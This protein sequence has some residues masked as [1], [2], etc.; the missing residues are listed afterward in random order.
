MRF[1]LL[2]GLSLTAAMGLSLTTVYAGTL[3]YRVHSGDSLYSIARQYHTSVSTLENWNHL[4]SDLIHPGQVL[5]VGQTSTD[6]TKALPSAEKSASTIHTTSYHATSQSSQSYTVQSG[7]SLWSISRK[8]GVTVRDIEL[9]NGLSSS[10][11]IHAGQHLH[12]RGSSHQVTMLSSR[13]STPDNSLT[14]AAVGYEIAQ[15]AKQFVGTPYAWG[16]TS[17]SGFDCSG[18]VQYVYA[19]FGTALPRTSYDQFGVGTSV[20]LSD[21]EPG[22]ILFFDTFGSGASHDG[23]Y[24]GNGEFINAASVDV[25]IDSISSAYWGGHFVGAKRIES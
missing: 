22:D 25:E 17:P 23:I 10:S 24:L 12:I 1:K 15:Y 6:G 5:V 11:V 8:F 20:S 2:V 4:H 14:A 16:G 18:F 21:L 19:H 9:W 7:D 3:Q 13:S